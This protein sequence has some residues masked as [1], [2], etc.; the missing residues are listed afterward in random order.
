VRIQT[1]AKGFPSG[2]KEHP[3][4][5]CAWWDVEIVMRKISEQTVGRIDGALSWSSGFARLRRVLG[6]ILLLALLHSPSK[7]LSVT[8]PGYSVDLAWD[9]SPSPEV[10]GYRVYYGVA[11]GNYTNSVVVGNVTTNTVPALSRGV[12]YFFAVTSY[13]ANGRE[14][15]FSNEINLVP[16]LPTVRIHVTATGQAVLNV[17]GLIG[18]NYDILATQTF[19]GWTVIG[20][21]K[22]GASGSVDFIDTNAPSFPRRFYRTRQTP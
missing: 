8:L 1:D 9:R 12:T 17:N 4:R 13:D 11:S 3:S 5:G 22:L 7:A 21:V 15:T 10:T 2:G 16:G 19:T 18:Q 20:T 6:G 14:S